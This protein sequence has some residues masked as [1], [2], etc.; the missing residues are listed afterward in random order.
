MDYLK[1]AQEAAR[2]IEK[3]KQEKTCSRCGGE[4]HLQGMCYDCLEG[5]CIKNEHLGKCSNPNCNAPAWDL[6]PD[7][8]PKCWA[9]LAIPG[10][11]GKH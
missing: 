2:K 8:E 9:F 10:L 4:V 1:L 6:G 5:H 3:R 11:F 7:G